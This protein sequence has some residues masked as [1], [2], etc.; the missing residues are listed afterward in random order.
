MSATHPKPNN[1]SHR[2]MAPLK[3]K[4]KTTVDA[5]PS[6]MQSDFR[7]SWLVK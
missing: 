3:K 5:G 4:A 1:P 7:T 6:A 2:A